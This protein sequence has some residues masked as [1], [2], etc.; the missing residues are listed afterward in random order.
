MKHIKKITKNKTYKDYKDYY[1]IGDYISLKDKDDEDWRVDT[2]GEILDKKHLHYYIKSFY[3]HKNE[4][5]NF[6]IDVNEVE[7]LA[8]PEEIEQHKMKLDA[9]KYN[10]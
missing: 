1:K 7:R 8:T 5:V 4:I 2:C 6:W 10:L 3:N 9:I